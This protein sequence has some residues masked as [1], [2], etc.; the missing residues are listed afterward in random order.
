VN[1]YKRRRKVALGALAGDRSVPVRR[2]GAP[3]AL[4][5]DP[6]RL[7][8]HVGAPRGDVGGR[9]TQ[10]TAQTSSDRGRVAVGR[11]FKRGR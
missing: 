10:G 8:R 5:N 9:E 11:I 4:Y 6:R 2:D 1:S 7:Q 3:Q